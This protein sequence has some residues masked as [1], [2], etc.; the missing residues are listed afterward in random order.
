LG[1][2]SVATHQSSGSSSI[3]SCAAATLALSS[4]DILEELGR[5]YASGLVDLE[6]SNRSVFCG[7]EAGKFGSER[8]RHDLSQDGLEKNECFGILR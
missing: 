4:F 5:V 8:E 7:E 3:K 6:S 2:L 1:P